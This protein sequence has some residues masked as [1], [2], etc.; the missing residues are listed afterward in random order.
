MMNQL[1]EILIEKPFNKIVEE[2]MKAMMQHYGN[3]LHVVCRVRDFLL[4]FGIK[5]NMREILGWN[6]IRKYD[7]IFRQIAY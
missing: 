4:F 2:I 5:K 1:K 7:S 6:C 3:P